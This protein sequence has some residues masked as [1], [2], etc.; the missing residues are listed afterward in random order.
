M[1]FG[2]TLLLLTPLKSH[3]RIKRQSRKEGKCAA[4]ATPQPQLFGRPR[5]VCG[6][7]TV[8]TEHYGTSLQ[9]A[10]CGEQGGLCLSAALSVHVRG[11][12][13][14]IQRRSLNEYLWL[15]LYCALQRGETALHMAARAGQSNVV[16]YLVQNGARVDAK[17][18]VN[19]GTTVLNKK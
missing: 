8:E 12:E 17:A 13:R 1:L 11:A 9:W 5:R 15:A 16:R 10:V 19:D 6:Q 4:Q 3:E 2:F 14:G 18:K 7:V